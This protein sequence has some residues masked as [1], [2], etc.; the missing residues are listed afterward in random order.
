MDATLVAA[1]ETA[2]PRDYSHLKRYQFQ[3]GNQIAKLG[4]RPK[5]VLNSQTVLLK[6]APKLAKAYVK[7]GCAGNATILTDARKWIMPTDGELANG[8]TSVPGLVINFGIVTPLPASLP[9]SSLPAPLL[10]APPSLS[11]SKDGGE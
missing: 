4:G 11:A 5:G 1:P 7:E 6:S 2:L 3:P 10:P 8:E 9:A